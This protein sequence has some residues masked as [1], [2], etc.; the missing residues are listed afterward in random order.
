MPPQLWELQFNP[1]SGFYEIK[2]NGVTYCLRLEET[3]L[4]RDYFRGHRSGKVV[5]SPTI[6]N[7]YKS[8]KKEDKKQV[9][10]SGEISENLSDF[11]Q[12]IE[13]PDY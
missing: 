6:S 9:I 3:R 1:K 12:D 7:W 8:I 10:R 5:K 11:T 13:Y 2:E 4:L